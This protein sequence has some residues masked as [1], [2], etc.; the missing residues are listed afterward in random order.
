MF[1]PYVESVGIMFSIIYVEGLWI[2][3]VENNEAGS[4]NFY[5]LRKRKN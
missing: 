1:E 4:E 2:D 5:Y 3:E